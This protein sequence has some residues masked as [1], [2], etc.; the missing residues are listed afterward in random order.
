MVTAMGTTPMPRPYRFPDEAHKHS[1][2]VLDLLDILYATRTPYPSESKYRRIEKTKGN[3]QYTDK[4]VA[5]FYTSSHH[6]HTLGGICGMSYAGDLG[7]LSVSFESN[8]ECATFFMDHLFIEN[9]EANLILIP[10]GKKR[11]IRMLRSIST[12]FWIHND[13]DITVLATGASSGILIVTKGKSSW[14]FIDYEQHIRVNLDEDDAYVSAI[15][16]TESDP[17]LIADMLHSHI[18]LIEK[19]VK[20]HFGINIGKTLAATGVQLHKKFFNPTEKMWRPKAELAHWVRGQHGVHGPII[21]ATPYSGK[22]FSV[23]QHRAY[24][25]PMSERLP[26][27]WVMGNPYEAGILQEGIYLATVTVD[28]PYPVRLHAYDN[29][30][31]RCTSQWVNHRT[32]YA[33]I[34]TCEMSGLVALGCTITLHYGWRVHR[35]FTMKPLL[36]E[37][38]RVNAQEAGNT[39]FLKALKGMVNSIPGKF[40]SSP[41]MDENIIS[42]DHP[43]EGWVICKDEHNQEIEHNWK[44]SIEVHAAYQNAAVAFWIYAKQRNVVWQIWA[45]YHALGCTMV[46]WST[47][48]GIF[49]GDPPMDLPSKTS[50]YGELRLLGWNQDI[51]VFGNNNN[52]VDGVTKNAGMAKFTDETT[53][54]FLVYDDRNM[55]EEAAPNV[56]TKLQKWADLVEGKY[57][58]PDLPHENRP[59]NW[60]GLTPTEIFHQV[61]KQF[62]PKNLKYGSL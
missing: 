61:C 12:L 43:G 37:I 44:R 4:T 1:P 54:L 5:L 2:E 14:T 24:S 8:E 42:T 62:G 35:W 34:P 16:D 11:Y 20:K 49:A 27:T 51:E 15:H 58:R 36:D 9:N 39:A 21:C 38:A 32:V 53:P 55:V 60:E 31:Q 6:D 45:D 33:I 30:F 57:K 10:H 56:T 52:I 26:Q 47:D 19:T 7:C 40:A 17:L 41:Y 3:T 25:K 22:G 18:V 23:D 28:S 48:G 13:Y 46:S 29:V 50:V 59:I